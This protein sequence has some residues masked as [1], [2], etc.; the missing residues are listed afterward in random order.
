MSLCLCMG[1]CMCM[2]GPKKVRPLDLLIAGITRSCQET[3]FS[4]GNKLVCHISSP[5]NILK[6]FY[7]LL[8]SANMEELKEEKNPIHI[9]DFCKDFKYHS[10]LLFPEKNLFHLFFIC[11][12]EVSKS[13]TMFIQ[14]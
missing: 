14:N 12:L 8:I 11:N 4:L 5:V 3:D 2:L 10:C 6:P 1:M 13:F 9:N 7:I